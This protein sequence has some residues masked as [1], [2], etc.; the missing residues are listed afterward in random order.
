M[1]YRFAPAVSGGLDE[2]T[3]TAVTRWKTYDGFSD[4]ERAAIAYAEL[5]CIDHLAIDDEFFDRLRR[6]FTDD[7]ILDLTVCIAKYMAFGRVHEVLE[8][9]AS[10]KEI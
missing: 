4:R 2:E 6:Q 7:E 10:W 5:F 3:L 8:F 9:E 1:E